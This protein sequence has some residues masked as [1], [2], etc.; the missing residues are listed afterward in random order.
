KLIQAPKTCFVD[1][2]EDGL[3]ILVEK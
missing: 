2:E 3:D 1:Q